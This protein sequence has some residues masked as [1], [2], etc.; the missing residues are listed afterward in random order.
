VQVVPSTLAAEVVFARRSDS[1]LCRIITDTAVQYILAALT[2]LLQDQIGMIC[3][4]THLHDKTK[5]VGIV[6][7]KNTLSNVCLEL[8]STAV[9]DTA[10]KV[11]LFLAEELTINIDLLC[12]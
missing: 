2:V 7:E 9:H 5:D 11:I 4:L 12:R 8:S 10:S 6:V 1:F 3:D